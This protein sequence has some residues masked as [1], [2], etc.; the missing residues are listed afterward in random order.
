[1]SHALDHTVQVVRDLEAAK[2]DFERLGF[3]A[4]PKVIHPS[5]A[6][7]N[8]IFMFKRSFLEIISVVDA[9]KIVATTP[10]QFSFA[11]HN[12]AFLARRG[13]GISL[14]ALGSQDSAADYARCAQ[15]GLRG[16]PPF[17]FTRA[18]QAAHPDGPTVTFT[19]AFLVDD[20]LPDLSFFYFQQHT[21]QSFWVPDWQ[22]QPNSALDIAE[23]TVV[24][25][26]PTRLRPYM[27]SVLGVDGAR[28]IGSDALAFPLDGGVLTVI[29]EEE[30]GNRFE[31]KSP[32]SAMRP[33]IAAV[34]VRVESIA[35]L[36]RCLDANRVSYALSTNNRLRP[37]LSS[38]EH[39]VIIDFID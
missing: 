5:G 11:D 34:T 35:Q 2:T 28:V 3:R 12:A 32:T 17:R 21:P 18:A 16:F 13:E 25:D 19:L 15:K 23:L 9:T 37:S 20:A 14:L 8:Y 4:A 36:R 22:V 31:R 29:S 30:Y 33:W 1:M 7:A 24:A 39:G 38:L 10:G 6:T 27:S 26:S